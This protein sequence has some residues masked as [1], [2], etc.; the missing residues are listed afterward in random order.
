MSDL[1]IANSAV[2]KRRMARKNVVIAVFVLIFSLALILLGKIFSII[3]FF[4]LIY[5]VYK[6]FFKGILCFWIYKE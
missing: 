2:E 4:G 6:G 3:G 1:L 5:A